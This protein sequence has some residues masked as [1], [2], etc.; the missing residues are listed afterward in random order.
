M[1]L[2]LTRRYFTQGTN[3]TLRADGM[4]LCFTI[5]LPWKE[6]LRGISCIPEGRYRLETRYTPH[7]GNHIH[8]QNVP[9]RSLILLHP[10]SHALTDL[11][12]CIAPVFRLTGQ[13]KGLESREACS[14]VKR[15]VYGEIA[16]RRSVWLTIGR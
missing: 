6:N 5:E 9:G 16:G 8:V 1:E 13:G 4:F 10:A 11:Q 2:Q 7:R 14:L 3:G 15:L 12:G